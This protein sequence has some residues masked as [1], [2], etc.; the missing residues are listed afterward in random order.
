MGITDKFTG[1]VNEYSSKIKQL[2][3]PE[4]LEFIKQVAKNLVSPDKLSPV[5]QLK[6]FS[7]TQIPLLFLVQPKVQKLDDESCEIRVN[8]GFITKNHIGSMYFGA[9]AIA[10]DA[11]VALPVFHHA[12]HFEGK[13]IVPIFKSVRAE[14]LK[15]AEGDLIFVCHAGAQIQA[16][17]EK[18]IATGERVTEEI[19]AEAALVESG[20]V[21][22]KFVLALSIKVKTS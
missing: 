15:R 22:S 9:Q 20:E 2:A 16:M 17:I 13:S 11:V 12:K 4:S 8:L 7:L 21:V 14:F 1:Y 3:D 10:A 5:W 19:A 18:T 6:I